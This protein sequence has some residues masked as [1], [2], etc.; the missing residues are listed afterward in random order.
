MLKNYIK[1]AVR[2]LLKNKAFSFINIVGLTIGMASAMLILLWIQNEVS[3]D[4]FH[5]KKDRLYLTFNRSV[6]DGKLWSWS[7]TPKIMAKTMRADYPQIED[8]ARVSSASFLFSVGDNHLNADGDFTDPGFLT[9]FSYPLIKGDPKTALNGPYSII[10]TQKLAKKLFNTDDAIGKVVK[11][12]SNANFTVTAIMKDLPNNTRFNFEYLLPWAY[13]KKLGWDEDNWGNNEVE[14][15]VLL[16]QGVTLAAANAQLKTITRSRSKED[17]DVFL[18]PLTKLRLY[19]KFENGINVGGR[20]TTVRIF[21]MIAV[22]ILFIACINFMNLSTARS[23]KRAKEVGIRKVAGAPRSLL[24]GQFLGESILIALISGVLALFAVYLCLPSFNLLVDKQLFLPFGNVYFWLTA[25][26]FILFTGV[27]AGSY[28][29][30]YLSSFKPISVLK[31][32]FKAA[33]ALVTPRKILVV[34]QFTFAIILIICTIIV[35]KQLQYAQDRDTGYKRDNIVFTAMSGT[36]GKNYTSIR[37]ELISSGAATSVT[38]TNSPITQRWSDS[39]GYDWAGKPQGQKLDFITYNVDGDITKTFGMKLIAGRDIDTKA[40]LTDSLALVVNEAAAKVLNFK[41]PVGQQVK[42]DGKTWHIIG[43]V[44]NFIVDSPYEPVKPMMIHGPKSWFNFVHYKLNPANSITEDMKRAEQVFK[45]YNSEY[46]F[47]Y[48]FADDDYAKKFSDEQRIGTLA[49]L[50][51]ALTIV[52][53]CLGLF[54]LATYM[55]QNRIKEIGVRKVLGASVTRITTLLSTDFLKLVLIS[56]IVAVPIAWYSMSE[57]LAGYT[58]RIE[59]GIWVFAVAG[60]LTVLIAL[61]TVSYQAIK[62][63]VANPVKSLRS[64]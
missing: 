20:I 42:K 11:V 52:I 30:F 14:T 19:S 17:I 29:A 59:M 37:D 47:E 10:I 43:V 16:K 8:A 63:A 12:D 4:Q 41:N 21:G 56:F 49:T 23:E 62:A 48:K 55:A 31:G 57:W 51:A 33:N 18:H 6:F 44:K 36:I 9:M 7:S 34:M 64:E 40:F 39:W 27:L 38:K 24:I 50:F 61:A 46:P 26:A 25:L 35:K 3:Y 58:Y 5:E 54:G 1:I 13:M 53:S 2:S 32:T 15:Y 45:K 60:I 28:P 22:F